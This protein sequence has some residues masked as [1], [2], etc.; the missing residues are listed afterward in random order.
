MSKDESN[1]ISLLPI[2]KSPSSLLISDRLPCYEQI[3]VKRTTEQATLTRW[4]I[5]EDSSDS[6]F[7]ILVHP[8]PKNS[9]EAE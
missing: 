6:E 3:K 2:Y 4:E 5:M 7:L 1:L 9:D 8:N